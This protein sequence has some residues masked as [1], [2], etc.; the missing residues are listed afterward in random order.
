MSRRSL[1]AFVLACTTA[2]A[3]AQVPPPEVTPGQPPVPTKPPKDGPTAPTPLP[4]KPGEAPPTPVAPPGEPPPP[5]LPAVSAQPE[6]PPPP[7]PEPPL[8]V[9][10][11]RLTAAGWIQTRGIGLH[12]Q[13]LML[14]QRALELATLPIG[15]FIGLVESRRLERR[16][17]RLLNVYDGKIKFSPRAKFAFG[18]GL[19][20]GLKVTRAHLFDQRADLSLGGLYRLNGDWEAE[21]AYQ[22][23]L[24]LPQGRGLRTA[25]HVEKDQNQRFYGF[26]NGTN[27]E[28]RRVLGSD[29]QS[30]TVEIDL[31]GVDR[32]T[33]SGTAALG[34]LRQTLSPGV[35]LG[36]IPVSDMDA[37]VPPGFGQS[38]VYVD[39][40]VV[41]RYDTRDTLGRPTA[42]L[43]IET[44]A[45]ARTDVTG[46]GLSGM[47]F[48]AQA[49]LHL[50]VL[51]PKRV[52]VLSLAGIAATP[53]IPGDEI[54][55][56]SLAVLGRSTL[57]GYDRERF[58]DRYAIHGTVEYRYPIY[59]YLAT[60]VG[61][62]AFM[63]VDAGTVFGESKLALD[64]LRYSVGTG[65]RG[66]HETKLLFRATVGWS[67]EG[68]QIQ[69]G[70]EKK[71]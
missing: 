60:S 71:L 6:P 29:D 36:E 55:L 7:A 20:G 23:K 33:Y 64:P 48:N 41:G 25:V 34:V 27:K 22:H 62:D 43:L 12:W 5:L 18:D 44:G 30:A 17:K 45:L 47:R 24:L 26:G 8:S 65:L 38:A 28:D 58:R 35:D 63:F 31:Q 61:L 53:L 11:E 10:A 16:V 56:D 1:I 39:L 21:L 66:A 51:A 59:E 52:V 69:F 57:R 50:P 9:E 37:T 40:Y 54:P 70:A 3:S 4:L 14:P 13:L 2:T 46:K 19:G 42:G 67:P 68:L 32:F 15:M 49:Q